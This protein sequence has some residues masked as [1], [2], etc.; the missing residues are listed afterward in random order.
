M[1]TVA[2]DID[3]TLWKIEEKT[4][5]HKAIHKFGMP[6]N[7]RQVPDYDLIQVLK[8][9]VS[10]GDK[11][12][13]WSAGGTDYAKTILEKLGLDQLVEVIPKGQWHGRPSID[14]CYDDE[15]VD[16]ATVNIKVKRPPLS[17]NEYEDNH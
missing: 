2:F 3:G 16:L 7:L 6:H 14:L 5:T 17:D 4:W 9:H 12:Y 1:I 10:N 11:V 8:W 15:D 13:V